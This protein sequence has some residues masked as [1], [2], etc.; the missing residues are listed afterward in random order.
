ML[1]FLHADTRLPHDADQLVLDGLARTSRS[2]GRFDV[3][4][5]GRSPML[6]LVAT[7]MNLRSRLTGIATGDQAIFVTRD[8]F[9]AAGGFPAIPLMEDV[10]LSK[11]LKR[12]RPAA[13]PARARDHVRPALGQRTAWC[14]PSC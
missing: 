2:W 10:A 8:A 3:T 6:A 13:L 12:T 5:R 1:L 4:H 11:R 14:A 7:M 9:R